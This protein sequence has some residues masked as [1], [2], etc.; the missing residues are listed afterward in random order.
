MRRAIVSRSRFLGDEGGNQI[1]ERRSFP[2]A[3]DR[4]DEADQRS[5]QFESLPALLLDGG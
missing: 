4:Y 5:Q 2:V 3:H 1:L